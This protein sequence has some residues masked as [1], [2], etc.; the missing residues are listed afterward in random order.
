MQGRNNFISEG[1]GVLRDPLILG[2]PAFEYLMTKC[3]ARAAKKRE[4]RTCELND[5]AM[6]G[7]KPPWPFLDH[8]CCGF[9]DFYF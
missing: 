7:R 8:P 4:A 3:A 2:V 9:Y 1:G 6:V 5:L